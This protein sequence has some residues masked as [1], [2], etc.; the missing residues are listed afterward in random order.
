ML[1]R[2]FAIFGFVIFMWLQASTAVAQTPEGQ[3]SVD[4]GNW[5]GLVEGADPAFQCIFG[6]YGSACRSSMTYH[7]H[8]VAERASM[9]PIQTSPTHAVCVVDPDIRDYAFFIG[10]PSVD[11]KC[12]DGKTFTG[13]VCST[14]AF[15]MCED[16]MSGGQRFTSGNPIDIVTGIKFQS[17]NDFSTADGRFKLTRHYSSRP[18][19]NATQQSN[20]GHLGRGWS[21]NQFPRM[22]ANR[23]F[24]SF[25][26]TIAPEV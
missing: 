25:C 5:C 16:C 8:E 10:T 6:D 3:G 11:F 21:F 20:H 2:I 15:Q 23:G 26:L 7:Y 4:G 12:P 9:P 14:N 1:S 13:G 24:Y 22:T 17:F 18:Y 19:G